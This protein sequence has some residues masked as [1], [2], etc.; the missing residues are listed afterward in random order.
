MLPTEIVFPLPELAEENGLLAVGGDLSCD[1]ILFGY[2]IGIFPWYNNP[3]DFMWWSPDPRMVIYPKKMHI[4]K[5]LKKFSRKTN[6]IIKADTAFK[7]TIQNCANIE[8]NDGKDTNGTWIL[9]EMVDAYFKLHKSGYAHSVE[10]WNENNLVGGLY[11]VS[12]GACFFGESMFSKKT[13]ASKLALWALVKK[14]IEW[15]F[16]F[17]DCQFYTD[18]LN[19]IGAEEIGRNAYLEQLKIS[20]LCKSKKGSWTDDFKDISFKNH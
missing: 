14:L 12:I 20:A 5:S 2:E 7:E 19:S 6:C 16:I 3:G 17:I 4:S 1:R 9:P 11:G 18:H 13:N 10:V 8:R 15:E